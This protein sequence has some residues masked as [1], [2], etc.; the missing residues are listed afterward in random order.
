MAS[1]RKALDFG[2]AGGG[3]PSLMVGCGGADKQPSEPT[4][5]P[6]TTVIPS[7]VGERLGQ[8]TRPETIGYT[9]PRS[10]SVH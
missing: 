4:A 2:V 8:S 6:A 5:T 9:W 1:R 3:L 10:S 7:T